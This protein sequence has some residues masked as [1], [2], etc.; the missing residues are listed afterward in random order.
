MMVVETS[1]LFTSHSIEEIRRSITDFRDQLCLGIIVS[2][3]GI[4]FTQRTPFRFRD[5]RRRL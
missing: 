5:I 3:I 2:G 4:V 1:L